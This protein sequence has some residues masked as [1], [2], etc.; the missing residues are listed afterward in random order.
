MKRIAAA[1]LSCAAL[2]ACGGQSSAVSQ[3]ER[4]KELMNESI[5][6]LAWVV[7][8]NAGYVITE[9]GEQNL[10]PTTD[11][12]WEEVRQ[13]ALDLAEASQLLLERDV[14]RESDTWGVF[15]N[16]LAAQAGVAAE[17]AAA[18]DDDRLFDAGGAIY[19]VCSGCHQQF[20]PEIASR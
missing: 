19:N 9:E 5:D 11:E 6:P 3:A 1:L 18:H 12:G 8:R 7:W 17:A 13:A 4:T 16:G 10:A 14:A 2:A 20:S 15:A